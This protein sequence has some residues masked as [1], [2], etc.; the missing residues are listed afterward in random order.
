MSPKGDY[1]TVCG[2]PQAVFYQIS[3]GI[4]VGLRGCS[5]ASY[6][7]QSVKELVRLITANSATRRPDFPREKKHPTG[8]SNGS[9]TANSEQVK[10]GHS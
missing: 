10:S 6:T 8:L 5:D 9:N 3:C 2:I 4:L 7:Y 1:N